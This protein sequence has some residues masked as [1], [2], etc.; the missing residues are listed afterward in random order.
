MRN[1]YLL[2]FPGLA[3]TVISKVIF[4]KCWLLS[5]R[6]QVSDG[7]CVINSCFIDSLN[8][9]LPI[10]AWSRRVPGSLGLTSLIKVMPSDLGVKAL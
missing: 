1:S 8:Q 6:N 3:N 2:S 5:E 7:S 10:G 4:Q 9:G